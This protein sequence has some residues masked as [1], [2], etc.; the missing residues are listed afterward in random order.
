MKE[1]KKTNGRGA[2]KDLPNPFH[3][4]NHEYE[5]ELEDRPFEEDVESSSATQYIKVYPKTIVNKV[6]SPDI[7]LMYSANPY[8][9]CEHG[10]IYCYA[11]PTHNYWGYSAG[12]EF[13]S[14]ILVKHNAA[15]LLKKELTAK[16]WKVAPVS[17]SGNTDCYQPA[18]RKFE[19]TRAMLKVMAELRHPVGIITKNSLITRDIDLLKD[20]QTD[21]LI[22][23]YFSIT[24][25]DE[26]L[27]RWMEP[28]TTNFMQ[29]LKAIERLSNEG[30]PVGVMMAPVI[31]GLNSHETMEIARLTSEAG[32]LDIGY[33]VVR[34]NGQTGEIFK[35]WLT[36]NYPDRA[37]KVLHQIAEMHGGSLE[38]KRTGKRMKGEGEM[39]TM[40]KDNFRIARQKYFSN[41]SLPE[42]NVDAYKR[43]LS[44]QLSLF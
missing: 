17:F 14:K 25:Q 11:R 7:P 8:Q 16:K 2:S 21:N 22:K 31:P 44:G 4:L 30:I 5:N 15:V 10:C 20:L 38:D 35:H 23:V 3:K 42:L 18:E 33:T 24:T 36:E 9:G 43:P 34:L 19:I 39:A 12:A 6:L 26:Q 37:E 1:K 40:I 29:K 28:R 41:K 13:E 32:A 27:R